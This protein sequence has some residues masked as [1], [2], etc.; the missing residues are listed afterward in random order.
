MSTTNI[1]E[2][3]KAQLWA[4]A[5]GRCEYE[6]CNKP[7]WKDDLTMAKMNKAYIAHIVADEPNGPRGDKK[8]SILLA[9]EFSNLMLMCD[10][11]HRLIDKEDVAGHPEKRLIAMKSKH[12]KRI[13]LLTGLHPD[14]K[15]HIVLYGSNIGQQGAPISFADAAQA[16]LPNRYPVDSYGVEIGVQ[17]SSFYDSEELFWQIEEEN[18]VRQFQEKI[19]PLLAIDSD[20]SISI[21]GLAPMPLLIKLGTLFSD[22]NDVAVFQKHR[23]PNTW[24]WQKKTDV[25]FKMVEP[26]KYDGIPVLNISLS[27]SIATDRIEKLFC[28]NINVWTL[29]IDTPEND[30]LKSE[31]ILSDFRKACRGIF[32]K[33]KLMHGQDAVLHVFP[34]MP[35]SAAIEFGR[36][37]M[38]KADLDMVI[39]DQNKK[40]NGFEKAIIIKN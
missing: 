5:A 8:R 19:K 37:R 13:E 22:L 1:P 39:Y 33:I 21:F 36:V 32:D 35:V 30:F 31:E 6:N 38:P 23:E 28:E 26:E 10:E 40:N 4:L 25:E 2:K 3:I 18:L 17:N 20:K 24:K 34:A 11:H 15:T 27:A 29:T 12:E 14:V 16:V 7:L 9:K